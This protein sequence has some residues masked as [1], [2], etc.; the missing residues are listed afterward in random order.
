VP[1]LAL[2]SDLVAK[3]VCF[4]PDTHFSEFRA[5]CREKLLAVLESGHL[6]EICISTSQ[7]LRHGNGNIKFLLLKLCFGSPSFRSVLSINPK[8]GVPSIHTNL[9]MLS[10]NG[11]QPR[12]YFVD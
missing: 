2:G 5:K 6:Q 1:H 10:P 12:R 3:P 4:R 7:L 8:I 11:N 9:T